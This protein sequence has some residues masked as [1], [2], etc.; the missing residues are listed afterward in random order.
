MIARSQNVDLSIIFVF[1]WYIL[2]VSL[3]LLL[4]YIIY[5][6]ILF[7]AKFAKEI[8]FIIFALVLLA[9]LI[10][11]MSPVMKALW[12]H[13]LIY[14]CYYFPLYVYKGIKAAFSWFFGGIAREG[15]DLIKTFTSTIF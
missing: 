8:L 7:V 15:G 1:R 9:I 11:F 13:F 12:K 2:I 6:I 14:P 10:G 4:L 5:D 3:V